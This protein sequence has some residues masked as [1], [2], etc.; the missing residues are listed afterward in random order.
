MEVSVIT[1]VYNS[2]KF[3]RDCIQSVQSQTYSSWEHILVDDCSTDKGPSIIR[4]L[5]KSDP[6][7]R[8]HRLSQNS[9]PGITRNK[10][11][12]LAKGRY[13]AFLDSDDVWHPQKLEKQIG[14]MK[15][16]GH[17]FT[18]TSYNQMDECGE[19][20]NK[21]LIAPAKITYQR[22]L[23]KNPIGCLTA[24]YDS[25][26]FGKQYMPAIRKRQDYALWLRLL[27]KADGHGLR[28]VLASYR[29]GNE[30]VSSNKLSLIKYEW[31]IYRKE[32]G[33]SVFKSAFYVL[34]AIFLKLKSYF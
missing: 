3:I 4:D 7:I 33:L 9:G 17:P 2:E 19:S 24:V 10:A 14:F 23:L 16:E 13:I 34:T 26:F 31:L 8:Y 1:A 28:E 30:S 18:F 15:K 22:A 6:R 20:L 27:K 32:E 5:A 11:I 29:T 21:E 12:E 25:S